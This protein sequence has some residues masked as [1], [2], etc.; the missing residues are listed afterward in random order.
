[1]Q[2]NTLASLK[3]GDHVHHPRFGI[4]KIRQAFPEFIS[5]P[6]FMFH[7]LIPDWF[8]TNVILRYAF[9]EDIVLYAQYNLVPQEE[10][11]YDKTL[12]LENNEFVHAKDC[13]P[14]VPETDVIEVEDA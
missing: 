10:I 3:A 1:M 8:F 5:R 12:L 6:S 11:L 14:V 13:L 4:V 7:Q 2:L 9:I